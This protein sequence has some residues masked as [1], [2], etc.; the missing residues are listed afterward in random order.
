MKIGGVKVQP[1]EEILVL[2]RPTGDDIVIRAKAVSVNEEFDKKVPEPV[3]PSLLTKDGEKKDYDDKDYVEAMRQRDSMRFAYLCIKSIEASEIEWEKVDLERPSTWVG[4]TD[5]MK[6]A[7]LS[8]IEI[9]RIVN[10]I[11]AANSLD[12]VKIE[13]A[14]KAFLLGQGA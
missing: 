11:L 7:G 12:E 14:R 3:A 5:E 4:W 6:E 13:E 9:G 10:L 1:C 8:D 2:P